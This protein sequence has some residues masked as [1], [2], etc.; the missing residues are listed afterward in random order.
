M[1]RKSEEERIKSIYKEYM[2]NSNTLNKWS[3]EI[4]GNRFIKEEFCKSF[5][6]LI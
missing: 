2:N 5:K 1:G 4:I 6:Y 3:S